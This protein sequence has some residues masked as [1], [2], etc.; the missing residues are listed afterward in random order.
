MNND[1]KFPLASFHI[2]QS[3]G[4]M[5]TGFAIGMI[6]IIPIIGWLINIV[7][8]FFLLYMWVMGLI[9][10]INGRF[11]VLPFLGDKY[12]EWFKSL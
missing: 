3:L 10:A 11:K 8:I 2:R 4:L 5:L 7:A 6:G 1:K 9:N 12:A